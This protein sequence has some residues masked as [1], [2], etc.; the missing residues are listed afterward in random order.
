MRDNKRKILGCFERNRNKWL[1]RYCFMKNKLFKFYK[2][3]SME[4]L[5]GILDFDILTCEL[6]TKEE[7]F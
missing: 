7:S 1:P 5:D 4:V 2:D 3:L 6:I